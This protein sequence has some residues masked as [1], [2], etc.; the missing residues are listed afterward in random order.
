MRAAA[1]Q[2]GVE[3]NVNAEFGSK[4]GVDKVKMIPD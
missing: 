1:P 3:F 4:Q 2:V